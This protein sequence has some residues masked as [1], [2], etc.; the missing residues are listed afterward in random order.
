MF[1]PKCIKTF[2]WFSYTENSSSNSSP[3]GLYISNSHDGEFIFSLGT[4][5]KVRGDDAVIKSW[6]NDWSKTQ[7]DFHIKFCHNML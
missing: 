2:W 5:E 7:N 1:F 6:M 4:F 3:S